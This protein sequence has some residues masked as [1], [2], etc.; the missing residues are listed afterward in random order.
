MSYRILLVGGGSGGHVYPLVAVANALQKRAQQTGI[1]VELMALGEGEFLKRAASESGLKFKLIVSGKMRRYASIFNFLDIFKL[2]VGFVQSLWHLYWFMPDAVFTKGGH[3]SLMPAI[4]AK[5]FAIPLYI[6]ESDS[7][8]G[9]VNKFL[10]GLANKV[11]ISFPSS[12]KYFNAAKTIITGNPVRSELVSGDRNAAFQFFKFDP[13]RKTIFVFG[14]SQGAKVLNG[15]IRSSLLAL[16]A[17]YQIIHQ[18]GESNY[19]D[20]NMEIKRLTEEKAGALG[21]TIQKSYRLFPFLNMN[22]MALAYAA[23]DI[24]ISRAGGSVFEM[25]LVGKPVIIIPLEGSASGHQRQNA[26]E[27]ANYGAVIIEEQNLTTHIFVNELQSI[28]RPENYSALSQ[29]IK[30]FATPDAADKIAEVLLN[31]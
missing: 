1:S 18:C 14:G 23:A 16:A 10:G 12:A 24:V 2:P 11:F 28:L 13:N 26:V 27:F 29:R 8:P 20:I 15:L 3:A 17:E 9:Q 22:E 31:K 5:L 6:H 25:A 21:E 4:A 19:S 7:I 30:Q